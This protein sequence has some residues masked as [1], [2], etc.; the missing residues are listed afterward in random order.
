L[1]GRFSIPAIVLCAAATTPALADAP[2]AARLTEPASGV[3]FDRRPSVDGTVFTCLGAGMRQVLVWKV[4]AIDFCVDEAAL[5]AELDRYFA[6]PGKAHADQHGQALA[7][8]LKDDPGFYRYLAS[9]PATKRAELVF[10]RSS[11]PE[12]VRDSFSKNLEKGMGSDDK[13]KAAIRDFVSIIDRDIHEGD[14]AAFVTAASRGLSFSWGGS[15]RSLRHDGIETTFWSTYLGPDSPLPALKES[16]AQ[17]VA[18]LR[19]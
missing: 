7:A 5:P 15:A 1:K 17:G 19:K 2:A 11:G 12:K 3:S 10:L 9:M 14:R 18:A 4:Y 13:A 6:G 8:A 16:V